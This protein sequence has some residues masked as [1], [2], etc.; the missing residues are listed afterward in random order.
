MDRTM[1]SYAYLAGK[2]D[3]G[4]NLATQEDE[5]SYAVL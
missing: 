2:Q 1:A 3:E 4:I 5:S